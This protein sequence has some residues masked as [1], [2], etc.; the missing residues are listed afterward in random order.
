MLKTLSHAILLILI[1]TAA[2]SA[3]P[4]G[5]AL[6]PRGLEGL[7]L[8]PDMAFDHY[9]FAALWMPGVCHSWRDI[10]T[11]CQTTANDSPDARAFTLHGLWPSLPKGLSDRGMKPPTWWKYGCYWYAPEHAI[12]QSCSLPAPTLPASLQQRLNAAMP[13]TNICLDRHEYTKHVACFGPSPDE[14]FSGALATL[15]RLNASQFTQW[16]SAHRG[17]TVSKKSIRHAFATSFHQS[18]AKALELRCDARPGS[19]RRDVLTQVW[20]TIPTNQLI[21]FPQSGSFAPG[22]R[23]NCTEQIVIENSLH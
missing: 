10:G 20:I 14:F 2:A 23:G 18:D 9:T 15:S 21:T 13:L 17:Q 5:A 6:G 22:R 11:V 4:Q 3:S 1:T 16:V 12:P 19:R 7:T 8:A